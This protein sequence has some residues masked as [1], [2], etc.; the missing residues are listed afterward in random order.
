MEAAHAA[1]GIVTG[2]QV[3]VIGVA[4]DDFGAERFEDVL[5]Y[6]FDGAGCADRH[7]DGRFDR[8]MRQNDASAT[9]AGGGFGNE[10]EAEAHLRILSGMR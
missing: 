6:G 4:E 3:E 8:G 2:A 5:R 1:D 9:A 10:I 7:K